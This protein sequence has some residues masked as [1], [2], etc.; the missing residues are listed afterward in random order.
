MAS[1]QRSKAL[2]AAVALAAVSF[3]GGYIPGALAE[4][5]SPTEGSASP[6]QVESSRE[7][8]DALAEEGNETDPHVVTQTNVTVNDE[9]EAA[10]VQADA[11][12]SDSE[13]A[14]VAPTTPVP[15]VAAAA[16]AALA[17]EETAPAA[18]A[19]ETIPWQVHIGRYTPQSGRY[20]PVMGGDDYPEVLKDIQV[21]LA[22]AG[23]TFTS[24]TVGAFNVPSGSPLYSFFT[25]RDIPVGEYQI[26]LTGTE[27]LEAAG[28]AIADASVAPETVW[29]RLAL[30]TTKS[31]NGYILYGTLADLREPKYKA[32]TAEQNHVTESDAPTFD[33][34]LTPYDNEK[35]AVPAGTSF[36]LGDGA[37]LWVEVNGDTGKVKATPKSSVPVGT[38]VNVP[39]VVTYPG[40][41]GTDTSTVRITVEAPTDQS[42][43]YSISRYLD[44]TQEPFKGDDSCQA[45]GDLKGLTVTL[46]GEDGKTYTSGA[47][48]SWNCSDTTIAFQD[49]GGTY[50]PT[51]TYTVEINNAEIAALNGYSFVVDNFGNYGGHPVHV[52]PGSTLVV[53]GS[54]PNVFLDLLPYQYAYVPNYSPL[55]VYQGGDATVEAPTF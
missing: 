33:H 12:T 46:T 32:M 39:V 10:E 35:D 44:G 18:D 2:A 6:T 23:G 36:S 13:A 47:S 29:P 41:G 54:L 50:I 34:W 24:N 49:F 42:L 22:G 55:T 28:Y 9:A 5:E 15:E 45:L 40:D 20:K 38:V 16:S 14:A 52:S 4:S 26:S 53:D 48:D 19:V 17:A 21:T 37:P 43:T 1:L 51:G 25:P 11:A 3:S 7:S 31:N 30:L 27:K 8:T